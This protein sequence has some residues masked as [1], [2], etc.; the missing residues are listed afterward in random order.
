[1]RAAATRARLRAEFPGTRIS[2][3]SLDLLDQSGLLPGLALF[4]SSRQDA[5][6]AAEAK[7]DVSNFLAILAAAGSRAADWPMATAL[8]VG[9]VPVHL[10]SGF[11][12]ADPRF[13]RSAYV[14]VF[15]DVLST[16][17]RESGVPAELL[18]A[19]ARRESL[20]DPEALS[21]NQ[22]LGLFQ[23]IP[24]TFDYLDKERKWRLME[25]SRVGSRDEY[26]LSPELSARLAG[27]WFS[28]LLIPGWA[29][30]FNPSQSDGLNWFE[31]SLADDQERAILLSLMEH[32][33]GR[34]NVSSWLERW[35][36]QGRQNDIEYMVET[37]GAAETRFLVRGV[38]TDAAIA[39]AV[40][41]LA[42]VAR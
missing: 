1:M 13:L 20:F 39:S 3:V 36:K 27:R 29:R 22:A 6:A 25:E 12:G 38:W 9:A 24:T 10:D 42:P 26:L 5:S 15:R 2:D 21:P 34:G 7:P 41:L 18:Y 37:A 17:S 31:A 23:F 40:G 8:A 19:L 11:I 33:A 30:E 16:A 28:K 35:R 4:L 32:N 14:P